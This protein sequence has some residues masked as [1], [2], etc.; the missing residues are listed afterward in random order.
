[1]N[2]FIKTGPALWDL[3]RDIVTNACYVKSGAKGKRRQVCRDRNRTAF[4][5]YEVLMLWAILH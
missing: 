5:Y 2:Q 1:M 3:H 4:I